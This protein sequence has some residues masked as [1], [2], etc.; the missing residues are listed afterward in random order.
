MDAIEPDDVCIEREFESH[1]AAGTVQRV[2]LIVTKPE[3]IAEHR[4]R[5]H[6]QI[7]GIGHEKVRTVHG[8]DS[9]DALIMGLRMAQ[10][11]LAYFAKHEQ[12]RITWLNGDDLG[13]STA[14]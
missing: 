5:C 4:W 9:L 2:R 14:L 11:L 6:A 7:T 3:Y 10:A 8:V 12:K 1:D 13:F